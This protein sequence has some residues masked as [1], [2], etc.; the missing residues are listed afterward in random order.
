MLC[1]NIE[2]LIK[3]FADWIPTLIVG[4][5]LGLLALIGVLAPF[6]FLALLMHRISKKFDWKT[7]A[8]YLNDQINLC[9]N[10][11]IFS[12]KEL[13]ARK[14]LQKDMYIKA[15]S[16]AIKNKVTFFSSFIMVLL[17]LLWP[18]LV[19]LLEMFAFQNLDFFKNAIVQTTLT[20]IAALNI[21]T[22]CYYKKRQQKVENVM[23]I[24]LYSEKPYE[25]VL[26]LWISCMNDLDQGFNFMRYI[27]TS[28]DGD[29]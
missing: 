9:G 7:S 23:R 12:D 17:T 13:V 18:S 20:T 24:N 16:Y 26:G 27:Q 15:K 1:S 22:Y 6:F 19:I 28:R 5:C 4:V 21:F 2:S 10:N 14:S 11:F 25:D 8:K 3:L 29:K